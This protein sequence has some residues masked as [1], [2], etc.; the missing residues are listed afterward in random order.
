MSR[1]PISRR[2]VALALFVAAPA[3]SAVHI[4]DLLPELIATHEKVQAAEADLLKAQHEL[5]RSQADWW[6]SLDMTLSQGYEKQLKPSSADTKTGRNTEELS[7]TQLLYDFGETPS[8]IRTSRMR[9]AKSRV[10]LEIAKQRLMLDALSAYLNLQRSVESLQYSQR[11]EANIKRQTG[12]E[13]SRVKRGSGLSTDVLQTKSSLAG[14]MATRVRSEGG[15][16]SAENRYRAIFANVPQVDALEDIRIPY[17]K[18]PSSLDEAIEVAMDKNLTLKNARLDMVLAQE[19]VRQAGGKLMPT[20]EFKAS[21][22]HKHNDGGTLGTKEEYLAKVDMKYNI[23]NGSKDTSSLRAARQGAI[24]AEKRLQDV[25]RTTEEQVRNAWQNL[26]TSRSNAQFLR[27]QA[28]ISGEFLDYAR[29][30]RKLGTRSLLDVLNGETAYISALSSAV[31]AETDMAIAAF[32]LLQAM[33]ELTP[34]ILESSVLPPEGSLSDEAILP[35]VITPTPEAA[36]A[37][38]AARRLEE[39]EMGEDSTV[40]KA[41]EP[42]VMDTK[43]QEAD[44]ESNDTP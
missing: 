3:V 42:E 23:F 11:S 16:V 36:R 44:A 17:E 12:L 10:S 35:Q 24:S 19:S 29:K 7:L 22:K 15:V 5:A 34:E 1:M 13:E 25:V 31:S 38:A 21:A 4:K 33:G 37:A 26:S 2:L 32:T 27:N 9:Y 30:E 39:A 41:P 28:N 43:A 8:K 14:A 18:I 40:Q 20:L 6:P